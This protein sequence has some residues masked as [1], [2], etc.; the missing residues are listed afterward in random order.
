[1]PSVVKLN[2]KFDVIVSGGS[3]ASV[4]VT[5]DALTVTVQLLAAR[6]VGRGVERVSASDRR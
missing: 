2:V 6:E 3:L 5:W 4:S 1:M